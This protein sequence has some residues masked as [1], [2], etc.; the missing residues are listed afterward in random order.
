MTVRRGYASRFGERLGF[1]PRSFHRTKPNSIWLHAVSVGEVISAVPLIKHIRREEPNRPIYLSVSTVAGRRTAEREAESLVDGVFYAPIDYVSCVRRTIRSVRP[2][3]LIVFETEI[4]PNLYREVKRAGASLAIINAR[5]SNRTWKRYRKLKFFFCPVL[6][7]ADA[8]YVQSMLDYERYRELGVVEEKLHIEANLKYDSATPG[9]K[10]VIPT[11]D[12]EQV[13]IAA[14]T[15]GP[16]ERG[17]LE[18]H[19]ID[20][21][22]IVIRAFEKLAEEFPKLLLILA[23]RQ[24]ARFDLV[25]QK[26]ER[27]SF[28]F[29]RRSDMKAGATLPL[30]LPGVLLLDTLGEL[31]ST[32]AEAHC[33]FVGGSIA[34]RG[35]HNI[36]EPAAAGVPIVVGPH[37]QNFN[38]IACDFRNAHA[39]VQIAS[40][41]ELLPAVRS[42]LSDTERARELGEFA[43]RV[44]EMRRG[45]AQRLAPILLDLY[46]RGQYKRP[47]NLIVRVCLGF[48]S[49]LWRKGGE[50]K[51]RRGE[52]YTS[53]VRPLP[54]PVVSI[55]GITVGGSGKTPF[56]I[57]LASQLRQR[58]YAPAILTRGYRRRSPAENVVLMPGVK[59]PSSLTG[60]EA[61]IFLRTGIAPIGIGKSRY[62]TAQVLLEQFPSTDILLLDDG[63]Q[64]ARL[65]RDFDIV[66]IDGLDP[67]GGREIV[68][69]G[70][71][72]EPLSSLNRADVFVV[73][74]SGSDPRFLAICE[75][76]RKYNE[77]APVFRTRLIARNWRDYRTGQSV[78]L[79]QQRVAAF[80]GLGN[81]QN[82]W[83]TLESLGVEVVFRWSFEDHH[84]YGPRELQYVAQQAVLHG[85]QVL[86]TTEKDRI[87]CPAR[88][89]SA[90]APLT[91]AWLEIEVELQDSTTFFALLENALRR[92]SAA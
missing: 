76:L 36:I 74:R 43:H 11:F 88:L 32:Y 71:L 35:G 56:T 45:V 37:M 26:L 31:S 92:R 23:P 15:V 5:I 62:E 72:R 20:E 42:L 12:A 14:S 9:L 75:Q 54:V 59:V 63:F 86:V 34:P 22:D 78:D 87:N 52:G 33:V 73:T 13:W 80:C 48:L 70:R 69:L 41:S 2:A 89:S 91:L 68:P 57:Y 53:S 10:T 21:D 3:L 67:L 19:A 4:W 25:A 29:V 27:I 61:Q 30:P 39:L 50:R 24:P 28:P 82:F 40:E 83:D 65:R 90:I 77:R 46:F 18:K 81:P 79:A 47:Q 1:V 44:V 84:A 60:D 8:V 17:S 51:R 58:G 85:A 6:C 38:A 16:N 7:L 64:H 55:G 49:F 66:V